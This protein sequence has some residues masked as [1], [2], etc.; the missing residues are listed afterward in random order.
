M[1]QIRQYNR[2]YKDSLL[3]NHHHPNR[4]PQ[5]RCFHCYPINAKLHIAPVQLHARTQ[6]C[7]HLCSCPT[8]SFASLY[9]AVR[10]MSSQGPVQSGSVHVLSNCSQ[11][12]YLVCF[13]EQQT[14]CVSHLLCTPINSACPVWTHRLTKPGMFKYYTIVH[15]KIERNVTSQPCLPGPGTD[16]PHL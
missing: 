3:V 13:S 6:N 15:I 11:T 9:A 16:F 10:H 14:L 5:W 4:S 2:Q 1:D 8:L 7:L 12:T